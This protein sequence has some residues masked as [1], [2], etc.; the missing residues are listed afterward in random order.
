MGTPRFPLGDTSTW[1]HEGTLV[2]S[3]PC[4]SVESWPALP[5]PAY[6]QFNE[7]GW[8][9]TVFGHF[10]S[11]TKIA[12]FGTRQATS[13]AAGPKL[14][15]T[16][17]HLNIPIGS[18]E[19]TFSSF[20]RFLSMKNQDGFPIENVGNNGMDSPFQDGIRCAKLEDQ[21]SSVQLKGGVIMK[22]TTI[23][24]DIAKNVFEVYV[25]DGATQV[26]GRKRLLRQKMLPWF[27]NPPPALVGMEACGG[28]I[29]GRG[30]SR[31]WGTRCG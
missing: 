14:C 7:A 9:V 16:N 12:P 8:G 4:P 5:F 1:P 2:F 27:A 3:G 21:P 13:S 30:S 31:S 23:G 22:R 24:V 26:V 20:Q 19:K 25:E 6:T 18:T 15:S 11:T 28:P 10:C 29:T 17:N